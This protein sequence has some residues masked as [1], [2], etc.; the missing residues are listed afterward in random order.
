MR[1]CSGDRDLF[2]FPSYEIVKE[3]F[4]DPYEADNRHPTPAIV[5]FTMKTFER[6]YCITDR[7]SDPQSADG[8][9]SPR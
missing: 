8:A 3:L 7:R 6:H 4:V 5:A 2:Y 1:D 9:S